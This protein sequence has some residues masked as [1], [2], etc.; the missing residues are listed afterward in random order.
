ML[1]NFK[2]T[3]SLLEKN[4]RNYFKKIIFLMFIAML[5]ET[6]GIAT[7][8][9]LINIFVG[10]NNNIPFIENIFFNQI[11]ETQLI[12]IFSLLILLVYV[13]KNLFLTYYYYLES[14]FAYNVRFNLGSRLF[15]EYLKKDY[16]F[17]LSTNSSK[18]ITKLNIE[19]ALF[20]G[21]IMNYSILFT[22]FLIIFG[23]STFL[24]IIRP[25]E[26]LVVIAIMAVLSLTFFII[27]KKKVIFYGEEVVSVQKKRNKILNESLNS[28]KD[29]FV[30][31]A[32]NFFIKRFDFLSQQTS[33]YGYK[34]SFVNKLP[35]VYFEVFAI[36][37]V[38]SV[39]F[40][41]NLIGKNYLETLATI[42]IFLLAALKIIPSTNKIM[43]SIQSIR[44]ADA[45]INSLQQDLSNSQE[46]KNFD[47]FNKNKIDFTKNIIFKD[48][49]YKHDKKQKYI[50]KNLDLEIK[51]GDFVAI[52]GESGSGKTTLINLLMGLLKPTEGQILADDTNIFDNIGSWRGNFGY[53]PQNIYLLDDKIKKNIGFGLEEDQ[54]SIDNLNKSTKYAQLEKFILET[55]KRY[56]LII[57]ENATKISGGQKQRIAI[58]RALYNDPKILILDEPTS[59]LDSLTSKDLFETL[60]KLNKQK[61]I[62]VVSHDIS[63]FSR[64]NKVF[65]IKNQS[66]IQK[67]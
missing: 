41:S 67:K 40:Y 44:Y 19:I 50:I 43:A 18:I 1:E 47:N 15:K 60:D 25:F 38:V 29:I 54:I 9:P 30:F 55:D 52:I 66:I 23:I 22:E 7:I 11:T 3:L 20:G 37:V 59:S 63:N 53:V 6:A 39:I 16:S 17:H 33:K 57:G 42:S 4:E 56:D 14:K 35:K 34:M 27:F 58:A 12:S 36:L 32:K 5:F 65:E 61:T 49:S 13:C 28:I 51:T 64:F 26:T 46:N 21:N 10:E 31:K 62:I 24:L 8:V 45:A 2:K 48:L